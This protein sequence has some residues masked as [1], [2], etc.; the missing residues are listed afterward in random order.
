MKKAVITLFIVLLAL[1]V[2]AL[3]VSII[4]KE[5]SI[6]A[7]HTFILICVFSTFLII[8]KYEE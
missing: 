6:I 5:P 7:L 8:K 1:N 4:R 3:I 2:M